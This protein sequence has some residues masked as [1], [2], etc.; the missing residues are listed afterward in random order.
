M[1]FREHA[2]CR[3]PVSVL[4]PCHYANSISHELAC[5]SSTP[6]TVVRIM[7][8]SQTQG[9]YH[10]TAPEFPSLTVLPS[11][12]HVPPIPEPPI[13]LHPRH[14]PFEHTYSIKFPPLF[15]FILFSKSILISFKRIGL[16]RNKSR[17]ELKASCWALALACP[18]SAM[19]VTGSIP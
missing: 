12:S 11:G 9:I 3:S 13:K 10:K 16:V 19:T 7:S 5:P 8:H 4:T 15:S 1:D 2:A 14:P 6:P 17:P 18:V